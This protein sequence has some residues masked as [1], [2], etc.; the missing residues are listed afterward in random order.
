MFHA[1]YYIFAMVIN[2]TNDLIRQHVN[3]IVGWFE[4]WNTLGVNMAKWVKSL[5]GLF[6]LLDKVSACVKR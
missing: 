6:N 5:L 2:F 3:I 4:V 1:N